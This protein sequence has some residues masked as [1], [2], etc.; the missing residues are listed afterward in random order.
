MDIVSD[1]ITATFLLG[2]YGETDPEYFRSNGTDYCVLNLVSSH[3][4]SHLCS[5]KQHEVR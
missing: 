5:G 1:T 2:R 4:Q 3:S